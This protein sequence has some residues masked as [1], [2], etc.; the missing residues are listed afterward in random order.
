MRSRNV[1][2]DLT[3]ISIFNITFINICLKKKRLVVIVLKFLKLNNLYNLSHEF[4]SFLFPIVIISTKSKK[5]FINLYTLSMRRGDKMTEY[6][7][8]ASIYQYQQQ[9]G[10]VVTDYKLP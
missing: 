2:A 8:K 9:C 3:T 1:L 4:Q 7:L 6:Q 10:L 5:T